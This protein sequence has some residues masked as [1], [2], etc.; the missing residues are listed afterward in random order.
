MPAPVAG[1]PSQGSP[2]EVPASNGESYAHAPHP[3]NAFN[4]NAD[5]VGFCTWYAADRWLWDGNPRLPSTRDA[6]KWPADA[7]G[8]GLT[9]GT[10]PVKGSIVVFGPT[11]KNPSGHV[12]Y[13]ESVGQTAYTIS[14]MNAG[15]TFV[16]GLKTELFNRV[17]QDTLQVGQAE[18]KNM[19]ILGFIYPIR[20]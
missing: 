7:R 4:W 15:H 3:K 11:K 13:V 2:Q 6:A 17:T 20:N 8:K 5:L 19:T 9:V 10:A 14:Q 16:S 12:A 18:Y 1:T